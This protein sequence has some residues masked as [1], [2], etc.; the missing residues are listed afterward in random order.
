MA[1]E[2]K[3][4][5]PKIKPPKETPAPSTK[6]ER[7]KQKPLFDIPVSGEVP[8]LDLLDGPS[9]AGQ[10]GYSADELESLSRLLELKLK[11][12]GV[13]AEVVAVYPGPVVTRF[14]TQPAAG[15]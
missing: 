14:E 4:A 9:D 8:P 5:P 12:F 3:R 11:D 10:R 13:V 1:R 2:K 7:E 6:V 15:V